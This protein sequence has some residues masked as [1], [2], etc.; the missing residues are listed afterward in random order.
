MHAHH[1]AARADLPPPL[2]LRFKAR[3]DSH[4][5]LSQST[6]REFN[7]RKA[8]PAQKP[9]QRPVQQPASTPASAPAPRAQQAPPAHPTQA[10]PAT[11][12]VRPET[13][14]PAQRPATAPG[15][16]PSPTEALHAQLLAEVAARTMTSTTA[17]AA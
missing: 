7:H 9:A 11:P 17:L 5:R 12:A 1:W 3:A 14:D 16:Q 2:L 8:G 10:R 6:L 13:T 15:A 4:A